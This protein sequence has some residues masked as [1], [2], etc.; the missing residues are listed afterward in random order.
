[1]SARIIPFHS[2]TPQSTTQPLEQREDDELMLLARAGR[3]EAFDELVQRYQLSALKTA[4]RF[5]GDSQTAIEVVQ[6]AFVELLRYIPTYQT[7]GKF[8]AFFYR[9]VLNR[10]RM[11]VRKRA[12]T[13][14]ML[15]T[16]RH[17]PLKQPQLP[18]D[19]LIAQQRRD[20]IDGAMAQLGPKHRAVIALRFAGDLSYQEIA[21]TLEIP[22]GTVKSRIAKGLAKL[23]QL[24]AEVTL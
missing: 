11:L 24:L 14:R 20:I 1:M 15:Q 17:Q 23:R 8:S 2:R 6:Q 16:V 22:I 13:H 12:S 3:K 21:D 19:Q 10:C 18:D 9:I 4:A 5:L 7:Q